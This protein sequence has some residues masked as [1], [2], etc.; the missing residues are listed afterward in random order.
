M[1]SKFIGIGRTDLR[2]KSSGVW[3][4]GRLS[5]THSRQHVQLFYVCAVIGLDQSD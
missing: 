2:I 3:G 1:L 5:S 4:N